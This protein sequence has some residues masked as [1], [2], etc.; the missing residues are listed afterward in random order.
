M[1]HTLYRDYFYWHMPPPTQPPYRW[2]DNEEAIKR[3]FGDRK[4][5]LWT[6]PLSKN[7]YGIGISLCGNSYDDILMVPTYIGNLDVDGERGFDYA[8]IRL[9]GRDKDPHNEYCSV[10]KYRHFIHCKFR[11]IYG[12]YHQWTF[13]VYGQGQY[14]H[15][16][17]FDCL[18]NKDILRYIPSNGCTFKVKIVSKAIGIQSPNTVKL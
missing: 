11:T 14:H 12:H 16:E 6:A 9:R 13:I 3:A 10:L 18:R 5:A 4:C 17:L 7:K 15:D 2:E 8:L 1:A